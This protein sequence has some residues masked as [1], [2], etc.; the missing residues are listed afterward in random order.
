M[1]FVNIDYMLYMGLLPPQ[2]KDLIEGE[3]EIKKF[4]EN[5]PMD[6]EYKDK[7]IE[8]FVKIVRETKEEK[9][10]GK[11][12]AQTI[13]QPVEIEQPKKK[14]GRPPKKKP[15]QEAGGIENAN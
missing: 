8:E 3:E 2:M 10:K 7:I 1:I 6:A 9:E 4:L 11:D 15:E 13:E 12:N 5:V 14:R